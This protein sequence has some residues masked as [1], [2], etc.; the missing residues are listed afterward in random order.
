[1]M[2]RKIKNLTL[3]AFAIIGIVVLLINAFNFI[4]SQRESKL[5]ATNCDHVEIGMP[6]LD[7]KKIMG[8]LDWFKMRTRSEIWIEYPRTNSTRLFY[9]SYPDQFGGSGGPMIYFDPNT[10]MVTKIYCGEK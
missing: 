9:L 5:Y 8:D 2:K 6:L 3:W 10:M 1:M 7:A 4:I